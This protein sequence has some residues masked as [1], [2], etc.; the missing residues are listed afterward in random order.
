MK[1]AFL[2]FALILTTS[3]TTSYAQTADEIINKYL[4]V[5]GG[6]EN[7]KK[8]EGIKMSA[9]VNQG[10]MDIPLDIFNLK[11]GRQMTSISFQGKP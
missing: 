2:F 5:T 10:G 1:T 7:W 11:D 9:K 6:V 8:L 3:F 4:T